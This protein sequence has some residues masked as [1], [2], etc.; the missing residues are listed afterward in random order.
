MSP[1]ELLT[2]PVFNYSR[3]LR[4]A[5]TADTIF[6]VFKA[7]SEKAHIHLPVCGSDWVESGINVK[8]DTTKDIGTI[9]YIETT[10]DIDIDDRSRNE[11]LQYVAVYSAQPNGVQSRHW[12]PGVFTRM[13]I[14]SC[15]SLALQWGTAGA[16]FLVGWFTPT[17]K[18]GCR[19]MGYLLYG[20]VSTIVWMMLLLSSILAHSSAADPCRVSLSARVTL[21]SSHI[22][23][24]TGKLLA[25]LNFLLVIM[26]CVFQYS[27]F[28]DRCYCN[29]S[30]FS[31]RG[32]AYAVIIETTAQA[33]QAKAAWIGALVLAC[34]SASGFL[35]ILN[36][37][38]D[39]VP[40]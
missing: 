15:A 20:V 8:S 16:A 23:R 13:V 2:P 1:D 3:S 11:S 26:A 5:S 12:A 14:A 30:V 4:W 38:L 18:I 32:A 19:S 9:Q 10:Q 22:L 40:S 34:T 17:T 29:S 25:L 37:L 7:A 39:T 24:W 6:M 33:A 35:V 31:R 21:A 27:S 28:Y 36:L